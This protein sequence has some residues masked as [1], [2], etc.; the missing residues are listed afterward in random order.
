L[1]GIIAVQPNAISVWQYL[2]A[3]NRI[4]IISVPP[5][6]ES[7]QQK[8]AYSLADSVGFAQKTIY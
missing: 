6:N 1:I 5:E 8:V 3:S 2:F 4:E 7:H